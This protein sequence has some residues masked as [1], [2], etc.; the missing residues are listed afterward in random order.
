[1]E[2]IIDV[3]EER[4]NLLL[5]KCEKMMIKKISEFSHL[6]PYWNNMFVL[7]NTNISKGVY[8]IV[9]GEFITTNIWGDKL[10]LCVGIGEGIDLEHQDVL[11]FLIEGNSKFTAFYDGKKCLTTFKELQDHTKAVFV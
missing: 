11:Y 8:G 3:I 5:K 1:M 4:K 7:I 2:K 6:F 9:P 10:N